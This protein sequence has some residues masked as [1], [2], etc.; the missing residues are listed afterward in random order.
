MTDTRLILVSVATA[1]ASSLAIAQ[2]PAQML[3]EFERGARQADSAF[4]R[5]MTLAMAPAVAGSDATVDGRRP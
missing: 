5:L 4:Q 1:L 2:T 3:Q